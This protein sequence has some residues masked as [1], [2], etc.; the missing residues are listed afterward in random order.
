MNNSG[1]E[2]T[3]VCLSG[4]SA[5]GAVITTIV[6][7]R[8][9]STWKRQL[10][11]QSIKTLEL[12]F[13][14]QLRAYFP[15]WHACRRTEQEGGGY[16]DRDKTQEYFAYRDSQMEFRDA[17]D[18]A[19]FDLKKSATKDFEFTPDKLNKNLIRLLIPITGMSDRQLSDEQRTAIETIDRR[20]DDILAAGQKCFYNLKNRN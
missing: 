17:W 19:S 5:L 12:S 10:A 15:Y 2:I 16:S 4:L 11:H 13:R 3:T 9:L 6:A 7:L 8:A 14:K 18:G 20:L 1:L